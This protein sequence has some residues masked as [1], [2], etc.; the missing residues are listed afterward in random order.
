MSK[1]RILVAHNDEEIRNTIVNSISKLDYVDVVGITSEGKETYNK[2]VE[3]KPEMVFSKY[4]FDNM[5][6][7]DLIKKSKEV[8][9]K[10][11][12]IF[13]IIVDEISDKE[14]KET[15]NISNNKINALVR[16]PYNDRAVEI[17]E[18]YKSSC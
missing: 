6:G 11:L 15:L 9:E 7:L 13:N 17:M 2:I 14:L 1:I 4:N 10:E 8:L 3:L 5:N 12:P 18:V 16:K